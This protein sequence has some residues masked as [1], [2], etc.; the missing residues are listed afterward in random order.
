MRSSTPAPDLA[1]LRTFCVAAD[2]GSLGR[3]AIRLGVSQPSLSKRLR[4]LEATVGVRLLDRSPHGVKLTPAG[5]R[6]YEHARGLLESADAVSEVMVGLRRS[7][8]PVRLAASHSATEAFVAEA[9]AR[10]NAK[11]QLAVEL[12][13]ANSLVVRDMVADGRAEVGFAA[14]RPHHSPNPGVRTEAVAPDAVICAVPPAHRWAKRGRVT[15]DE[16]LATPM[17]VRDP[18]SNARWTVEAALREHDLEL[19][20][21]AA[22]AAT[23]AAA[24][25]DARERNA[26]LLLSRHVLAGTDF[27]PVAIDGLEFPRCYEL[28]LPAYGEPTGEVRELID[29]VRDHIRIWLR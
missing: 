25:R 4:S 23:P 8:G 19:H 1:E 10:L 6:L 2:L 16:F 18:G 26:P 17:V 9:L 5:R 22:E 13:T 27:V 24:K 20:E 29:R 11:R 15:L 12:V 3:A 14:S 7:D 21:P 28:V